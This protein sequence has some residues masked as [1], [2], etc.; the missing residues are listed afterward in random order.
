M[1]LQPF[2]F[3]A[4]EFLR[5]LAVGKKVRVRVDWQTDARHDFGTVLVGTTNLAFEVS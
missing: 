5:H 1:C 3:A 2:A 4:R